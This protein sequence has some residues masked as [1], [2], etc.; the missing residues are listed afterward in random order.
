MK[1]L[2]AYGTT[3]GQTRKICEYIRDEA[4][5]AGVTVSMSDTTGPHLQPK[6]FDAA[7]IAAS[8]HY[9]EY[10]TSLEH[11]VEENSDKL[12]QIPTL[13][14]SVSLT[15]ASDEPESGKEL[16]QITSRFLEK[17]GWYPNDV[18]QVAGAL[19]YSKYNFFKKFIMRL[20][21]QKSG[22]S[23][24]TSKDHEY[25]DW[26]QVNSALMKLI[27]HVEEKEQASADTSKAG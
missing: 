2:V 1:L 14:L 21:A 20:I 13:F 16:E 26:D 18:E 19:R 17:T 6:S 25:T 7:V 12:N 4:K 22:G 27:K 15:A 10:Q 11:F 24:D 9:G 3:E 8:V 5:N 23:T